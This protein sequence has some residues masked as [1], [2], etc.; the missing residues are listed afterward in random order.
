[1][2][3]DLSGF[4]KNQKLKQEDYYLS[5]EGYKIFTKI[6]H[7]KRGYCCQSNC[8]NCPYGYKKTKK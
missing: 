3:E 5:P 2:K 7:L 6:Y 1:M 4:S 8:I